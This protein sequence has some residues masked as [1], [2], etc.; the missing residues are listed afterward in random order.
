M[1][2]NDKSQMITVEELKVTQDLYWLVLQHP[3]IF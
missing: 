2:K 1:L 3:S